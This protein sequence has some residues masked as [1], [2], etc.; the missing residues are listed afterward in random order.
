[1]LSARP[2]AVLGLL[3][4]G[5]SL[6]APPS[7]ADPRAALRKRA[8][9]DTPLRAD[10][11]E[12]CDRIGGRITGTLA[13][14]QAVDWAVAKF[15]SLGVDWVKTESYPVPFLWVPGTAEVTATAPDTFSLR[16][17][18]APGTASTGGAIEAR[19][20]DVGEGEAADWA[21]V[22]ASASGAIALVHTKEMKT[23]EDLF[24][25]YMR[26]GPL[27]RAAAQA[28]VKG[29]VIQSTRPRG[30]LYQ[31]PMVF[32]RT[33]SAVPVALVAREPA[34]RLAWLAARGEAR[35]RIGIVNRI[36]PTYEARN[37]VAE[38]RGRETPDE[39]VVLGAHLDSWALGTGAEDNGVNV[40]LVLDVAR[41]F[42]ELGLRPRRSVRFVLFTGEEQGM[43]G[44]AGYTDRHQA[45]L[46][47]H[48]GV[49]IFDVG[50]GRTRG[51]FVS[52][53]PE[54]RSVV[55][56]ALSIYPGMGPSA[57]SLE[58]IDGTDNFDFLLSGV[59]N[60]VA[61][62]DPAPYLLDYHAESDVPDR[63]NYKEAR[64]NAGL[65][66]TLVWGLAN[67]PAPIPKRQT[68]TEVDALLVRTKLVEQMQGFEQ[69]DDWKAGRRGFPAPP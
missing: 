23:F 35:V 68:R 13:V 9:G 36:G 57:Q 6:A 10:T 19:V 4:V 63:V 29:L 51:F 16:A 56:R 48:A 58:G 3:L 54:L 20:V 28:Q 49:V 12:L 26:A 22:G 67:S 42:H 31:H 46:D 41:G 32:G 50:S 47:R 30:L 52:G 59:P 64:R 33:P 37:V 7:P 27:M 40:A 1:M 21:R 34:E 5:P 11:F 25:E 24:A 38:I 39:F 14:D 55:A 62:Q 45:E 53:R 15:E 66:A 69:W 65:A 2:L 44:S 61:D 17:V 43:W 18:A 8:E 60:F